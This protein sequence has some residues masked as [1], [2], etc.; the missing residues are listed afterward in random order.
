[1]IVRLEGILR[2]K[3]PSYV[4][5][6]C[7]GVGYGVSIS[8]TTMESL[9]SIGERAVLHTHLIVRQDAMELVGFATPSEREAFLLLVGIPGVGVRTALSILSALSVAQ[10]QEAVIANNLVLLQ[11]IP[12][13]GRKTAER[14]ILEL[15]E[16]IGG[17]VSG[18]DGH[19]LPILDEALRAM[20]VLGYH[21]QHAEKALRVAFDEYRAE[22]LSPSVELLVKRALRHVHSTE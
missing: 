17:I 13:I 16:K 12:G 9:P 6:E 18:Q 3:S 8:L 4:V 10:L 14:L 20:V 1:M 11:R 21:R 7:N 19:V 2:E 22:G 15:R 5:I